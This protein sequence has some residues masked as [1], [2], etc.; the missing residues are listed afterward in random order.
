MHHKATVCGNACLFGNHVCALASLCHSEYAGGLYDRSCRTAY[1]VHYVRCYR[2]EKPQISVQQAVPEVVH[3][4]C[5]SVI[6]HSCGV[7]YPFLER[8][9]VFDYIHQL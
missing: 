4:R 1:P 7:G 3:I 5:H 8:V 6:L 9:S 2:R